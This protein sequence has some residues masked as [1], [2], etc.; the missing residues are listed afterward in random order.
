MQNDQSLNDIALGDFVA[1]YVANKLP[2]SAKVCFDHHVRQ[3]FSCREEVR[4]LRTTIE[5]VRKE[6]ARL[7]EDRLLYR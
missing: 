2:D 5:W 7:G 6:R 1:Q 4:F 3:C